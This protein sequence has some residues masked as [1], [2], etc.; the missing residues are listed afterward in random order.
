[1]WLSELFETANEMNILD[2]QGLCL[3][4]ITHNC[5]SLR[6][7]FVVEVNRDLEALKFVKSLIKGTCGLSSTYRIGFIISEYMM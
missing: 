2:A 4:Q 7:Y 5:L 3:P 6:R 1:M